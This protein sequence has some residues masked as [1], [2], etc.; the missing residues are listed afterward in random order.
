M[1]RDRRPASTSDDVG[2]TADERADELYSVPPEEFVT[3][4]DEF[5]RAAKAA[6][7]Q[8]AAQA[9][10]ALRKPSTS[11]WLANQL[12]RAR[13]D[14]V[15]ALVDLGSALRD[16]QGRLEGEELRELSRQRRKAVNGLVREARQLA[17]RLGRPVSDEVGRQ[18]EEILEA[19]LASPRSAAQLQSGRLAA[20]LE[21]S[22]GFETAEPP[23]RAARPTRT[24]RAARR[25]RADDDEARQRREE[26]A[27]QAARDATRSLAG[28]ISERDLATAKISSLSQRI[29]DLNA[30]LSDAEEQLR[31]AKHEEQ[32][33]KHAVVQAEREVRKANLAVERAISHP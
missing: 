18:L 22:G 20:A 29:F 32:Q 13:R 16:A 11:A 31:A 1:T 30:E 3:K 25:K 8:A 33:A 12:V 9:I 4:R 10:R 26:A 2:A 28:R 24:N 15:T 19:A 17:V 27:R 14:D 5:V 21:R 23:Q 7:D 6:G